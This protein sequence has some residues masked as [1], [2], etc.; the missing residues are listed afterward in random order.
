[1]AILPVMKMK[2]KI[3]T[4]AILFVPIMRDMLFYTIEKEN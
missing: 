2:K 4:P 3:H 1:M